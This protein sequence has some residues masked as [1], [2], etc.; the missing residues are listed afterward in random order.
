MLVGDLFRAVLVH[1]VVVAGDQRLVVAEPEL[2]LSPVALPLDGLPAQTRALH[3][4]P[5]VA[6]QWLEA[7]GGL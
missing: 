4:Q 3:V 6:Q 5:D 7:A 2:L 1:A